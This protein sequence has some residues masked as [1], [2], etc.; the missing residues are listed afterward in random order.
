MLN[1]GFWQQLAHCWLQRVSQP[2][3]GRLIPT[4]WKSA[5]ASGRAGMIDEFLERLVAAHAEIRRLAADGE[6]TRASIVEA[7]I[8][9]RLVEDNGDG[10]GVC[11]P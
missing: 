7:A 4:L 2:S 5:L 6:L 10:N 1:S 11:R 3:A 9:A 8:A